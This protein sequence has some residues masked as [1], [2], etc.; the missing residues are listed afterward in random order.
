MGG[1]EHRFWSRRLY[2]VYACLTEEHD[3]RLVVVAGLVCLLAS[4][5]TLSLARRGLQEV[6]P[7][8]F[9][10]AVAS[11]VAGCGIWATHF[12]AM[13]AF[14]NGLP[15]EYHA[16]VTALSVVVAVAGAGLGLAMACGAGPRRLW[17]AGA[18]LGGSV[19]G[20]H[21]TGMAALGAP[22]FMTWD[23]GLVGA[24]IL[25]GVALAAAAVRTALAGGGSGR[26]AYG[27]VL[28][29]VGICALHF[30]AMGALRFEPSPLLP[31][32]TEHLSSW[33]LAW[34]VAAAATVILIAAT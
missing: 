17:L 2:R 19:G 21:F 9:W 26:L 13:L 14:S 25:L 31:V 15:T 29:T 23:P 32:P 28:L 1:S 16:G 10:L 33:W 18:V 3:L 22:A 7:R 30:T 34:G 8:T 4:W 24:S 6:R 27:A 12:I 5:T 20:M 11:V